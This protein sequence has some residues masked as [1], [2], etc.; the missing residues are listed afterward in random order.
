MSVPAIHANPA[1]QNV[2]VPYR[3]TP[4]QVNRAQQ[5]ADELGRLNK[6][7]TKGRSNV[8]GMLGEEIVATY[9]GATLENRKPQLFQYDIVLPD[10]STADVKTKK[11][12]SRVAPKGHYTATV[13][14]GNTAQQCD[15]YIFVRICT[16]L[17]AR[18]AWICGQMP[19][20]EFMKTATFF[21]RGQFDKDNGYRVHADCFNMRIDHL[22][23]V[24]SPNP[25]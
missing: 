2:P 20:E 15:R 16:D 18:L 13:W 10:G 3:F 4:A 8:Y 21:R 25:W 23:P 1:S 12:T 5:R 24:I 7:I 14:G 9:F 17:D 11:T 6:S 22:H 19:K